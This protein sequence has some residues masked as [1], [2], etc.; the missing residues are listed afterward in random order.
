MGPGSSAMPQLGT[1]S[2]SD[3]LRRELDSRFLNSNLAQP[4]MTG[5]GPPGAGKSLLDPSIYH[6]RP[7]MMPPMGLPGLV[8]PTTPYPPH[9]VGFGSGMNS[10]PSITSSSAGGGAGGILGGLGGLGLPSAPPNSSIPPKSVLNF[11]KLVNVFLLTLFLPSNLQKP[12]KW[13]AMHVR[14]AWEIYQNQQ[15]P[16]RGEPQS[17]D[18]K[19][20]LNLNF[21]LNL[22]P[23]SSLAGG[24]SAPPPPQLQQRQPTPNSLV[25]QPP[26]PP[27]SNT[28]FDA[29]PS[30]MSNPTHNQFSFAH[31]SM[32]GFLPRLPPVSGQQ[33]ATPPPLGHPLA[34]PGGVRSSPAPDQW[35]R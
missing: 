23:K 2:Y 26:A 25:K 17:S 16:G 27:A 8:P 1:E 10:T 19:R 14:I 22:G 35:N 34:P 9:S 3:L 20:S 11:G 29:L 30:P 13:N 33:H 15:K 21:S 18:P 5:A 4:P 28:S 31:H 32:A 12:G 6:H 7:P 24:P